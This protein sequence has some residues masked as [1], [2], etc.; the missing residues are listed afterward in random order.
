M[1]QI[2]AP[3][4]S[5]DIIKTAADSL[6][7]P[8]RRPILFVPFLFTLALLYVLI[9]VV[10]TGTVLSVWAVGSVTTQQIVALSGAVALIIFISVIAVEAITELTVRSELGRDLDLGDAVVHALI[11]FPVTLATV[12]VMTAGIVIG[13]V[14]LIVPGLVVGARWFLA[15]N[16]ALLGGRGVRDAIGLS[17]QMTGEHL[18]PLTGLVLVV[19]V[20]TMILTI[21][22][23]HLPVFGH[24]AAAWLGFAW[25]GIAL[26]MAYVRLGGP[27][28]LG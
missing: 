17:W 12:A 22:L 14:L 10:V 8:F 25:G 15:P 26:A 19:G 27:V 5:L 11:R 16:T 23:S 9:V 2:V 20:G 7:L 1:E 28:D 18:L 3:G 6:V 4:P 24:L 21:P 13:M